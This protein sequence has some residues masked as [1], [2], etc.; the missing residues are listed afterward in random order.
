MGSGAGEII[1]EVERK[2]RSAGWTQ[3]QVAK[4]CGVTQ[5]HYSKIVS[6]TVRLT[7]RMAETLKNWSPE[8]PRRKAAQ[9]TADALRRV[10]AS[11]RREIARIEALLET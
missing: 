3:A 2:R 1:L 10:A 4:A 6:E 8:Q 7:P 5:G 9:P 11:L